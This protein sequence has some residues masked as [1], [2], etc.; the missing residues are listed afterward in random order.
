MGGAFIVAIWKLIELF[1]DLIESIEDVDT[2]KVAEAKETFI[3]M[4]VAYGAML[5]AITGSAT[6]KGVVGAITGG[7]S[8]LGDLVTA[9]SGGV[10]YYAITKLC[11]AFSDFLFD[12]EEIDADKIDAAG[13]TFE[14]IIKVYSSLLSDESNSATLK[15]LA[16]AVT[17]FLSFAG[18]LISLVKGGKI[19]DLMIDLLNAYKR[20]IK[21]TSGYTVQEIEATTKTFKSIINAYI[22]L[23][24]ALDG[25]HISNIDTDDLVDVIEDLMDAYVDTI[26]AMISPDPNDENFKP[27]PKH[28]DQVWAETFKTSETSMNNELSSNS[29]DIE[30]VG[31]NITKGVASGMTTSEAEASIKNA[32]SQ[33]I[34]WA[35]R[36]SKQAADEHSPSKLMRDTVGKNLTAGIAVGMAKYVQPIKD[37]AVKVTDV[38]I[39]SLTDAKDIAINTMSDISGEITLTPV[40]DMSNINN[41]SNQIN[42]L[43]N[44]QSFALNSDISGIQSSMQQIQNQDPNADL[45]SAINGLKD[46]INNNYTSYNV[47]GITYDD[48]SN[49]ASAVKDLISA[50]NV[51]RRM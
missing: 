5:S 38:L 28:W 26:Q 41:A 36:Y 43:F 16:A 33:V 30:D 45:M 34:D 37:S 17:G 20:F 10:L 44:T 46:N 3:G 1:D 51:Q 15:G 32:G 48:G 24:E 22:D 27:K 12:I 50:T 14:R 6:L 13:K 35:V 8:Y 25:I 19:Y 42:D 47:N 40:I 18:D 39:K 9:L 29:S 4:I 49:I 21:K 7:S 11:E 2:D 31:E 23:V